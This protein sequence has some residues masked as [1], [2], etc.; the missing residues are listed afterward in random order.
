MPCIYILLLLCTLLSCLLISSNST[1]PLPPPPL[2]WWKGGGEGDTVP[3]SRQPIIPGYQNITFDG[4]MLTLCSTN[5]T[6]DWTFVIFGASCRHRI[7]ST[8]NLR[9]GSWKFQKYYVFS[10]GPW[11]H[12]DWRGATHSSIEALKVLFSGRIN[13]N[14]LS[15]P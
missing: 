12:L 2:F 1:V 14:A 9:A 6:Y 7:L 15:Q 4:T 3:T 5:I 8:L 13:Q 10:I 11:K